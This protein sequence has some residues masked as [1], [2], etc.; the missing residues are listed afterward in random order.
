MK[1]S[2][3]VSDV[4]SDAKLSI[5]EKANKWLLTRDG[6]ILWIVGMRASRHFPVTGDTEKV[7]K[8]KMA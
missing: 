3:L 7:L 2:R 6:Q 5:D 4:F 1:G 8:I